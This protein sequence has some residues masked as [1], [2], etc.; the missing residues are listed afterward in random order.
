MAC[1]SK[2]NS[3][4]LS[5]SLRTSAR[6]VSVAYL[7]SSGH[8]GA[9][10]GGPRH[11]HESGSGETMSRSPVVDNPAALAFSGFHPGFRPGRN[12]SRPRAICAGPSMWPTTTHSANSSHRTRCKSDSMQGPR[13]FRPPSLRLIRLVSRF[14]SPGSCSVR[15]SWRSCARWTPRRSMA[16]DRTWATAYSSTKRWR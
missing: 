8:A 16:C 15:R 11:G 3:V 2:R 6:R 9:R 5:C 7:S 13:W 4:T 14:W 12:G 1:T 10:A